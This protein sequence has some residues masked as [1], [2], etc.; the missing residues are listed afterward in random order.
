MLVFRET[1]ACVLSEWSFTGPAGNYI[2][3]F[4]KEALEHGCRSGVFIV[5]SEHFSHLVLVI[6]L[7][8][9]SS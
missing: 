6:L 8:S 2:F 9:L 4:A 7:L 1:S 3:R 5:K